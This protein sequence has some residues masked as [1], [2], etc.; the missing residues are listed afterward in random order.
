MLSEASVLVQTSLVCLQ[1]VVGSACAVAR[2][3]S[4]LHSPS[5]D[6]GCIILKLCIE[7]NREEGMSPGRALDDGD[8]SV[9]AVV[10]SPRGGVPG[11][12]P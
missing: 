9:L 6:P 10:T 2:L 12:V 7:D 1:V 8:S 11:L 3:D 4:R 5:E